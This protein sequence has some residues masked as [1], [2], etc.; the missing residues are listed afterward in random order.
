[1]NFHQNCEGKTINE[2]GIRWVILAIYKRDDLM[3]AFCE[4]VGDQNFLMLYSMDD[5]YAWQC[6]RDIF[7]LFDLL[8]GKDIYNK[9]PIL[10]DFIRYLMERQ[11]ATI[12]GVFDEFLHDTPRLTLQQAISPAP[13]ASSSKKR[14]M[15]EDRDSL[16]GSFIDSNIG[17]LRTA[18]SQE[19]MTE[20]QLNQDIGP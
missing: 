9:C 13:A 3:K 6:K 5:S 7:E 8:E 20:N 11:G 17:P 18:R 1:M 14:K 12:K 4:I 2:L 10:D 19:R 15:S 16:V